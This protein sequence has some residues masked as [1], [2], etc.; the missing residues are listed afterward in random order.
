LVTALAIPE[1]RGEPLA[2]WFAQLC[3]LAAADLE[4]IPAWVARGAVEES[5][6]EQ[7][8]VHAWFLMSQAID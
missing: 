8:T 6:R 3:R 1:K 2:R 4:A 5:E 7:V